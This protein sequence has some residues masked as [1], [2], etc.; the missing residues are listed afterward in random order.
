[1]WRRLSKP[2]VRPSNLP[3]RHP[4]LLSPF[5]CPSPKWGKKCQLETPEGQQWLSP[6]AL[7]PTNLAAQ[8]PQVR[9]LQPCP[10]LWA[11]WPGCCI[12][13]FHLTVCVC[14]GSFS[15]VWDKI[16]L[17]VQIS[18]GELGVKQSS[19]ATG[20]TGSNPASQAGRDS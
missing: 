12:T 4:T 5:K 20:H 18:P 14:V 6:I 7:G 19:G 11:P 17:N 9:W 8:G 16:R 10:P 15:A 13:S 3:S 2:P 1:M